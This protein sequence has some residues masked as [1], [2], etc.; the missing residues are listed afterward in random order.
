MRKLIFF[1]LVLVSFTAARADIF[2]INPAQSIL[3]ISSATVAGSTATPQGASGFTTSYAGTID[4]TVTQMSIQFNSGAAD[5]MVSGNY[6]PAAGGGAGTAPG[7]YGGMFTA[8]GFFPGTFAVRDFVAGLSSNSLSLT[9][10][11]FD[12]SQL[13][14]MA[15]M[16]SIDY[17]VAGLAQMGTGSLA[18]SS[19][20]NMAA[21]PGSISLVGGVQTLTIPVD[22]TFFFT[23]LNPNDSMV[24]LTG[25]I[26]AT[27]VPEPATYL[28]LGVGL[29]ICGQHFRKRQS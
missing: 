19:G 10:G 5:A 20:M 25:N 4:A 15:V 9:G 18:G 23:A 17:R 12:A 11:N 3:A 28:L 13:L 22:V 8:L 14:L 16:G 24:R 1:G 7:D 21:A 6:S 26:V 29:L 2:T 27:A